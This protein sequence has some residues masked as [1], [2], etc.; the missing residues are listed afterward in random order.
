M[1]EGEIAARI[2][3][4]K[5]DFQSDTERKLENFDR[6]KSILLAI[7]EEFGFDL[8]VATDIYGDQLLDPQESRCLLEQW[9]KLLTAVKDNPGGD[10]LVIRQVQ[11]PT[12]VRSL[13]HSPDLKYHEP[14]VELALVKN[15]HPKDIIYVATDPKSNTPA[16]IAV[17]GEEVIIKY[18]ARENESVY[19]L[20]QPPGDNPGLILAQKFDATRLFAQSASGIGSPDISFIY[21]PSQQ[22]ARELMDRGLLYTKFPPFILKLLRQE[23]AAQRL[24]H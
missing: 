8:D 6:H 17:G 23:M 15:V 14:E 24:G 4:L 13:A 18:P 11:V 16:Y 7:G 9:V 19:G 12:G 2:K 3:E 5:A 21:D 20:L 22:E 10:L 1:N